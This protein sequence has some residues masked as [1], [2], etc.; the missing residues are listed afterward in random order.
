MATNQ[1]K[2]VKEVVYPIFQEC[3]K[4]SKDEF[5]IKL[6]D[7]LSRGKCPKGV[8]IFNGIISSTYKRNGFSYNFKDEKLTPEKLMDE[9]PTLLKKSVCIYSSKD[10]S[11]NEDTINDA[12]SEYL[13]TISINDWKKV[14]NKKMKENL[15]TNFTIKMKKKYKLNINSTK[16]LYTL[17]K[18][19]YDVYKTH[20]SD[21]FVMK[22]DKLYKIYDIEY[23]EELKCFE[24]LRLESEEENKTKNKKSTNFLLNRWQNY[25]SVLIKEISKN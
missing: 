23:N 22:N 7:D 12:N 25:I 9:L 4:L 13:N 18:D 17:I 10:I 5:W 16:K 2:R 21:D 24:N 8:M 20:K 19:S 3:T 6:F 1:S 14:K 15:I 11:N